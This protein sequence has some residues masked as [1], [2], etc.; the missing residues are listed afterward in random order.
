MN[1]R[2]WTSP[3]GWDFPTLSLASAVLISMHFSCQIFTRMGRLP[4]G[5]PQGSGRKRQNNLEKHQKFA[6]FGMFFA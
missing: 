6:G 1:G 5:P 2:K 4:L 3:A